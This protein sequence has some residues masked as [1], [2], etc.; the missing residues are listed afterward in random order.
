MLI[1]GDQWFDSVNANTK[2]QRTLWQPCPFSFHRHT[3]TLITA[4]RPHSVHYKLNFLMRLKWFSD[5][6]SG[7]IVLLGVFLKEP[8]SF[9]ENSREQCFLFF[10]P[11]MLGKLS[12]NVRSLMYAGASFSNQNAN[13][14]TNTGVKGLFHRWCN[15][16]TSERRRGGRLNYISSFECLSR[17]DVLNMDGA[18]R[19]NWINYY[20]QYDGR[21]TRLSVC[22]WHLFKILSINV[23]V[24][25]SYVFQT[26]RIWSSDLFC[27]LTAN[28]WSDP[29]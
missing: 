29:Y 26:S 9:R 21:I 20:S 23:C 13:H 6:Y 15:T 16:I 27:S 10:F 7:E 11:M 22:S 17:H 2:I 8:W 4:P 12:Y 1:S 18:R 14:S 5:A 3:V 24:R 25:Y 28:I 19:T